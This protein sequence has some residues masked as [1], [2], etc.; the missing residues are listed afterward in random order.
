MSFPRY[1]AYKDSGVEWLGE[2]PEHW[3]VV[4][5]R[6][7]AECLDGQRIPLNSEQ[8]ARPLFIKFSSYFP[9]TARINLNGHEYAKRQLAQAGIAYAALDNGLLSCADP[10]A[11]QEILNGLTAEKIDAV[12]RASAPSLHRRGSCRRFP[13]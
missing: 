9:Y 5:L 13:L 10:S 11:L 7:L 12:V 3:R 1:P 2:V 4:P 8:R 6:F